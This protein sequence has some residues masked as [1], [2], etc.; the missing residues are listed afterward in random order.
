MNCSQALQTGNV[1][2]GI[3]VLV[4]IM[5]VLNRKLLFDAITRLTVLW[6]MKMFFGLQKGNESSSSNKLISWTNCSQMVLI[7]IIEVPL[8][9]VG[10]PLRSL[11]E[12][13]Q[14]AGTWRSY[15]CWR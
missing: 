7:P 3:F 6:K 1:H 10:K 11:A 2:D 9:L 8:M 15:L 12:L 5:Q 14:G 4:I 13:G